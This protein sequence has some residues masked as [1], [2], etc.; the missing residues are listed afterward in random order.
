LFR[1]VKGQTK[2]TQIHLCFFLQF[3]FPI[4]YL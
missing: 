4:I 2:L 3:V 1:T